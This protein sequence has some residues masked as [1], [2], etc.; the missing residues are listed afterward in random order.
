MDMASLCTT[1][2]FILLLVFYPANGIWLITVKPFTWPKKTAQNPLWQQAEWRNAVPQL[3]YHSGWHAVTGESPVRKLLPYSRESGAILEARLE[4]QK[5]QL[6]CLFLQ[7]CKKSDDFIHSVDGS[8]TFQGDIAFAYRKTDHF[9][10]F[11]M[12]ENTNKA[13]FVYKNRC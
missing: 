1:L 8:L 2:S 7:R 10:R 5:G 6:S 9:L 4:F 11:R 3:W 13:K 12:L